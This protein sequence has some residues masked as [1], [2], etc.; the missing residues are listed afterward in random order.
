MPCDGGLVAPG[1]WPGLRIGR[2]QPKGLRHR[3]LYQRL[4][5]SGGDALGLSHP[6]RCG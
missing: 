1:S 2:A 4:Y 6:L 5:H 3:L